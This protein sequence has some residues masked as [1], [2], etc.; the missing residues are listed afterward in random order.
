MKHIKYTTLFL[1]FLCL[2]LTSCFQLTL[3]KGRNLAIIQ[4]FPSL[5]SQHSSNLL[6]LFLD[7]TYIL[8]N[9]LT[10]KIIH[11]VPFSKQSSPNSLVGWTIWMPCC[12]LVISTRRKSLTRLPRLHW[13]SWHRTLIMLSSKWLQWNSCQDQDVATNYSW[14]LLCAQIGKRRNFFLRLFQSLPLVELVWEERQIP[15][16]KVRSFVF[17]AKKLFSHE[18]WVENQGLYQSF[19]HPLHVPVHLC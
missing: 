9:L 14:E 17:H 6:F 3:D 12:S 4:S 2:L 15:C 7:T 8:S 13:A 19:G 16:V 10:A 11:F 5:R 1:S 18:S